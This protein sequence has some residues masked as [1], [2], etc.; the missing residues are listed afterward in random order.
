MPEKQLLSEL[1]SFIL[2]RD[3]EGQTVLQFIQWH[4]HLQHCVVS[5][6]CERSNK[7]LVQRCYVLQACTDAMHMEASM[8]LFIC[9]NWA[10]GSGPRSKWDKNKSSA[11]LDTASFIQLVLHKNVT[12]SHANSSPQ[13]GTC[14]RACWRG[15][16]ADAV[17]NFSEAQFVLE[18]GLATYGPRA[19]S[20]H[21]IQPVDMGLWQRSVA[22]GFDFGHNPCN[23]ARRSVGYG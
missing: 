23:T 11:I 7:S 4:R 16:P 21:W 15:L 5:T 10:H 22:A 19:R 2:I 6:V 9:V 20:G 17:C 3:L 12:H 18:Q 14:K 13:T 1:D 8:G